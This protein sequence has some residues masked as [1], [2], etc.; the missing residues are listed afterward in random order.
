MAHTDRGLLGKNLIGRDFI[1]TALQGESFT[2]GI[3]RDL[4]SD[5]LGLNFSV[6][7][8]EKDAIIGAMA[9]H[10]DGKLF[11]DIFSQ[12]LNASAD[13]NAGNAM[14]LYL[15]DPNGIVM[16]QSQGDDWLYRSLGTLSPEAA[17]QVAEAKPLGG[18]CPDRQAL[19]LPKDK[20]ARQPEPLPALQLLGDRVRE[21]F[22]ASRTDSVRFCRTADPGVAPREQECGGAW[23]VAAYAPVLLPKATASGDE[24]TTQPFM[25]VVDLPEQA[26]LN[27]VDR[28]RLFGFGIAALMALLAIVISLLLARAIAKPINRLATTAGDVEQDKPFQKLSKN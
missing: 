12:T 16:T 25:V 8:R 21:A 15:V 14:T 3:R 22:A 27:A 20:I 5:Q 26:F 19:C 7:I 18:V 10:L 9:T 23:H 17:R 1:K 28:Q 24:V 11:A 6:P 4:V 13:L 2:S